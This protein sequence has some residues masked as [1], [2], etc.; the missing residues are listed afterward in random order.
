MG[1]HICGVSIPQREVFASLTVIGKWLV[2]INDELRFDRADAAPAARSEG[3]I[4]V[5]EVVRYKQYRKSVRP[6][7]NRGLLPPEVGGT[8]GSRLGRGVTP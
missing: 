3:A 1:F 5:T 8:V 7:T 6:K 4:G 2:R